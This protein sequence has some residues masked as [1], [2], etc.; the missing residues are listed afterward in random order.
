MLIRSAQD[1][2]ASPSL[3]SKRLPTRCLEAAFPRA[4]DAPFTAGPPRASPVQPRPPPVCRLCP[5]RPKP[6]QMQAKQ[7]QPP[8]RRP[9]DAV[10]PPLGSRADTP[11]LFRPTLSAYLLT[12]WRPHPDA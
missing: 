9:P 8:A 10:W 11:A 4:P 5:P 1:F 3:S 2:G 6:R 12:P 7:P